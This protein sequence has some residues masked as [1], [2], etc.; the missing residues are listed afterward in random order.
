MKKIRSFADREFRSEVLQPGKRHPVFKDYLPI[1]QKT[2]KRLSIIQTRVGQAKWHGLQRH[3][4]KVLVNKGTT[5]ATS[6]R[7]FKVVDFTFTFS[8]LNLSLSLFSLVST[9]IL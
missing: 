9:R 5:D 8:L 4:S 3:S 6:S 1:S 7:S 2:I